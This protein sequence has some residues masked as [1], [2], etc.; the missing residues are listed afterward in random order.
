MQNQFLELIHPIIITLLQLVSLFVIGAFAFLLKDAWKWIRAHTS[1][2]TQQFLESLAKE[3]YAYAEKWYKNQGGEAKL[4]GAVN[5][6]MKKINLTQIGLTREDVTGAVQKAWQDYN[7]NRKQSKVNVTVDTKQLVD[8]INQA[9][10]GRA[11][12]QAQPKE[13][14]TPTAPQPT[15]PVNS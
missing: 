15:T 13:D 12:Q 5:Y 1:K 9:M 3:G 7:N 2:S 4:S 11:A 10:N 14:A 8:S 6:V